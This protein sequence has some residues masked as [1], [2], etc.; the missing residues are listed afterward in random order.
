[1]LIIPKSS[2]TFVSYGYYDDLLDVLRSKDFFPMYL[3]GPSGVGKTQFVLEACAELR[4]Q[5]AWLSVTNSTTES[6][7]LGGFRLV[8]GNTVFFHGPIPVAMRAGAVLF[9]DEC[10]QA[11]AT[12]N[13]CLQAVLQNQP[14]TLKETGEIIYPEP[15]FNVVIAANTKGSGDDSGLFAGAQIQNDA[16]LD[17]IPLTFEH[18]YPPPHVETEILKKMM[19]ARNTPDHPFF[20]DLRHNLVQWAYQIR[21]GYQNGGQSHSMSTRRILQI[22]KL[23]GMYTD[24]SKAIS[25]GL[26]RFPADCQSAWMMAFQSLD[27]YHTANTPDEWEAAVE[28]SRL[29]Q[30]ANT[31]ELVITQTSADE[32]EKPW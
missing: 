28:K 23:Y 15:G 13:M 25:A 7:L 12:V 6:A 19:T 21:V 5:C 16:F 31:A 10:D 1:M 32:D 26:A 18:D 27:K 2:D 22:V 11:P 14:I 3:Q 30:A 24:K 20:A 29:A 9:L 17:R 4:R 8:D